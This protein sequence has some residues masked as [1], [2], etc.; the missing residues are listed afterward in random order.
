[1]KFLEGW[2]WGVSQRPSDRILVAIQFMIQ[3]QEF[4]KDIYSRLYQVSFIRQ[5]AA[6]V[7]AEVWA[8][9]ALLVIFLIS[10]KSFTSQ[11][12]GGNL[13]TDFGDSW[14]FSQNSLAHI[15]FLVLNFKKV[16]LLSFPSCPHGNV[17]SSHSE[18]F[19][20][21]AGY[22]QNGCCPG[23]RVS[24]WLVSR[25]CLSALRLA[26]SPERVV[27]ST[28]FLASGRGPPGPRMYAVRSR[29]A[30]VSTHDARQERRDSAE[31]IIQRR[32]AIRVDSVRSCS[33]AP[34]V[35]AH[36]SLL[37]FV[38]VHTYCSAVWW[39]NGKALVCVFVCLSGSLSK[40]SERIL[41]KFLEGWGWG[42]ALI[43]RSAG[44]VEVD[45]LLAVL[46]Q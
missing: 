30:C 41:M 21:T 46:C 42:G 5:V 19:P 25:V 13:V 24:G 29:P 44:R 23:V 20:A 8:V 7:S 9:Q 26:I 15:S 38:L 10:H 14:I 45:S 2:W 35:R 22:W 1:M 33:W 37:I 12:A 16:I 27:R 6:L 31:C 34:R 40:S 11:T 17:I 4:F 36:E 28:S 32:F 43:S 3:I 18:Q 39:R